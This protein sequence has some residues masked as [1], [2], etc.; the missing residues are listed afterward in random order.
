MRTWPDLSMSKRVR[1]P[2]GSRAQRYRSCSPAVKQRGVL[3][4]PVGVQSVI[5][6][7]LPHKIIS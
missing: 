3:A 2:L 5:S 4:S 6:S 1:L 7:P